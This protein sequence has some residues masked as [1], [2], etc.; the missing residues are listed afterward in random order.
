MHATIC[1]ALRLEF[2]DVEERVTEVPAP[3]ANSQPADVMGMVDAA[4]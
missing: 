4:K 3:D 1:R 2:D